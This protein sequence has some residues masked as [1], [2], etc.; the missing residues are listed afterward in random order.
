MGMADIGIY[1]ELA[2]TGTTFV[3]KDDGDVRLDGMALARDTQVMCRNRGI[4]KS[5]VNLFV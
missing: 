5:I 3:V 1:I 4:F 2:Q